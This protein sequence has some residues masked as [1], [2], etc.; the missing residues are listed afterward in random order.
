MQDCAS[1][2]Q[3]SCCVAFPE[4]ML[5]A[6]SWQTMAWTP[7]PAPTP[8]HK[9]G[10]S[11]CSCMYLC[12]SRC[13]HTTVTE[14]MFAHNRDCVTYKALN[15]SCLALYRKR[16]PTP[17]RILSALLDAPFWV[18]LW[19]QDDCSCCFCVQIHQERAYPISSLFGSLEPRLSGPVWPD[20]GH[21]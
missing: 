8:F 14:L 17:A 5:W 11:E 12:V 6:G 1:H 10:L 20:F 21:I 18:S 15:S 4:P 19:W 7:N 9:Q 3:A 13:L 2:S 16:W